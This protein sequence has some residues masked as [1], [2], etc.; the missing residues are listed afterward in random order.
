M[1]FRLVRCADITIPPNRQRTVV[2]TDDL[3]DSVRQRGVITPIILRENN[4]LV[5]GERRLTT[6]IKLGIEEI[7]AVF[8]SQLDPTEA[9]IIELTEN[10]KRKDLSWQD[11]VKAISELH[12]TFKAKNKDWT[13]E[14]T[15]KELSITAQHVHRY[16]TIAEEIGDPAVAKLESAISAFNFVNRRRERKIADAMSQIFED[17]HA[18]FDEVDVPI[19]EQEPEEGAETISVED[20][21]FTEALQEEVKLPSLISTIVHPDASIIIDSFISWAEAYSGPQFNFIHCDFPYG[22]NLFAGKQSGR[23]THFSYDDESKVYWTLLNALL[24]HRD[25]I[26]APSAHIMFWFG[27]DFYTDTMEMFTTRAPDLVMNKKPLIWVKS[28]NVGIVADPKRQGRNIYEVAL[29]GSRGDRY[30]VKPIANAYAGPTD[31]KLHPSTKPEP[32]LRHFFTMFVDSNTRLLDPTCGSG[33][34]LRAAESLGAELVLGIEKNEEI[35]SGAK[36]ALRDFRLKRK[37]GGIVS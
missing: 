20:A 10:L 5:A 16:C 25:K 19:E 26:I 6:C 27:M 31:R 2:T 34:S 22:I 13:Y 11:A 4:E 32:M 15:G 7:P 23:E 12:Q 30:I 18:A 24:R 9:K 28:D 29:F 14:K 3:E 33:S 1:E 17:V 37:A 21:D 36:N 8:L 35:G